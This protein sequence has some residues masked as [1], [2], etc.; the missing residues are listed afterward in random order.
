MRKVIIAAVTVVVLIVVAMF[1][2]P[3]FIDINQHR[4]EIQ[5]QLQDRLHR[6]VKLGAMSLAVF[7]L[8]VEVKDV[9]IDEDPRFASKL[10]FA[11]VGEMDISVKLFPLLTK[12]VAIDSLTLKRP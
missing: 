11:Q 6:P 12:T 7:P 4:G 8:R 1:L 3:Y 5:A 9:S 2:L 10:P